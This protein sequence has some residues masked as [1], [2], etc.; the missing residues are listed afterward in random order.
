MDYHSFSKK[1]STVGSLLSATPTR[2]SIGLDRSFSCYSAELRNVGQK[3]LLWILKSAFPVVQVT[4]L[5][6][7]G[8]SAFSFFH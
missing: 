6:Q 3:N 7:R 5:P 1:Y 2:P 4:V 8:L